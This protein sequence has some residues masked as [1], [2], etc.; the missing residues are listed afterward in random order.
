MVGATVTGVPFLDAERGQ[1]RRPL[2]G[3]DEPISNVC[4][5][6]VQPGS[7]YCPDCHK[8]L[9]VKPTPERLRGLDW[10]AGRMVGTARRAYPDGNINPD[11]EDRT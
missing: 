2:W 8:V 1:C 9:Y 4:G 3:F 11:F 7:S 10:I 5:E 6:P